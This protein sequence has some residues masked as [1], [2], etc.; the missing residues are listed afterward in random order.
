MR[1]LVMGCGGIGG[2]TTALLSEAGHDVTAMTT[3]AF[4]ADA[5]DQ[6]GLQLRGDGAPAR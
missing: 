1:L 4:I 6:R 2:V 3:N 5:I